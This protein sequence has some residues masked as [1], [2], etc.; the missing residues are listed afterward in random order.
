MF[1]TSYLT[2]GTVEE[3]QNEVQM[4]NNRIEEM[5]KKTFELNQEKD[6]LEK[7]GCKCEIQISL[8]ITHVDL[9]RIKLM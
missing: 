9:Y 8:I 6:D 3:L 7:V 2:P 5:N 4:L 1:K